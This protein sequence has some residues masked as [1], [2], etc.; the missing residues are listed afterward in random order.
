[1]W[2]EI[3]MTCF[4]VYEPRTISNCIP[5]LAIPLRNLDSYITSKVIDWSKIIL[6][7]IFMGAVH[8]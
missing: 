1:M 6:S 8:L 5:G 2:A 3:S 7:I 4:K